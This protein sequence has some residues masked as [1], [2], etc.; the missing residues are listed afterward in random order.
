MSKNLENRREFSLPN[1][2]KYEYKYKY[3]WIGR[4]DRNLYNL[5]EYES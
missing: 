3:D 5:D 2:Y 1:N 4:M